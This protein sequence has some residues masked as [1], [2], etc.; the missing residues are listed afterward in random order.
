MCITPAAAPLALVQI[1]A[2]W[3]LNL[4]VDYKF[5]ILRSF[6]NQT[7]RLDTVENPLADQLTCMESIN[8][9]PVPPGPS[10]GRVN[11]DQWK[12]CPLLAR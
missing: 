1:G 4:A 2:P 11:E 7:R 8:S 5:T 3:T 9:N 10:L 12:H 6:K